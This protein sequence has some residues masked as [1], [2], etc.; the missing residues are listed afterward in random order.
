MG[1]K[2][3]S[4]CSSTAGGCIQPP[5]CLAAASAAA[6]T[7]TVRLF[8]EPEPEHSISD[9]I[10]KREAGCAE[11]APQTAGAHC[12]QDDSP[13]TTAL[14]RRHS[15]AAETT[16]D[17]GSACAT[18]VTQP[19]EPTDSNCVTIPLSHYTDDNTHHFINKTFPGL[20]AIHK[21]PWIF[22]VD[23][24]LSE[25]ECARLIEASEPYLCKAP[26]GDKSK[27]DSDAQAVDDEYRRC[28]TQQFD[29]LP[30]PAKTA[31]FLRKRIMSL[32]NCSESHLEVT[33]ITKYSSGDY[34]RP[35]EDGFAPL[36]L[37]PIIISVDHWSILYWNSILFECQ[38]RFLFP[39]AGT[40]EN[41][42]KRRPRA[43]TQTV[44]PRS[45]CIL[46]TFPVVA[47]R[48]LPKRYL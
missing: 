39:G 7:T 26:V 14:D 2:T 28:S 40:T 43:K 29:D 12:Q 22:E 31:D 3:D 27:A 34:F 45:S 23:N 37:R 8:A 44:S 35:H 6:R 36:L 16:A 19:E 10:G 38:S 20:R 13:L 17:P 4:T 21:E 11:E 15:G 33:Q 30:I 18:V 41:T 46:A 1:G 47:R 9:A 5:S 32:I 42:Q 25:A 48:G 24:F